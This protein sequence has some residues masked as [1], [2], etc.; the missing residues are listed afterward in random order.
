[1][2]QVGATDDLFP[3]ARVRCS[4]ETCGAGVD[5]APTTC[6]PLVNVLFAFLNV[7]ELQRL[8]FWLDGGKWF[9]RHCLTRRRMVKLVRDD[10]VTEAPP[11][12]GNHL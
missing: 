1:M 12:T 10:N 5:V 2:I 9:C 6:G 8:G 3:Y 4:T 11:P 7:L